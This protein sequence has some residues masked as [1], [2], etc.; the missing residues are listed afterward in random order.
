MFLNHM[1]NF[2]FSDTVSR[3]VMLLMLLG[4]ACTLVGGALGFAFATNIDA[5]AEAKWWDLMT[6][7]GTCG[8]VLVAVLIPFFQHRA[9]RKAEAGRK[10][11]SQL[12]SATRTVE[13]AK[14]CK[15]AVDRLRSNAMEASIESS[16]DEFDRLHSEVSALFLQL[17]DELSHAYLSTIQDI[18]IRGSSLIEA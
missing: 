10:S 13:I 15:N 3:S 14:R 5:T 7:F 18:I 17:S 6:A 4:S 16:K 12:I 8:A 2:L 11:E 9:Y 1:C